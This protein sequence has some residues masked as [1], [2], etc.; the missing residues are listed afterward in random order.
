M[1]IRLAVRTDAPALA[2]LEQRQPRAAGWG[3]HGFRTELEQPAARIWCA[4]DGQIIG[5]VAVRLA[6]GQ[7]EILNVAVDPQYTKQ[8]IGYALLQR[9]LADLQA[10]GTEQVSLE[11]AQDNTA[12]NALYAKAGF[13]MWGQRKDFYGQGKD[14]WIW[15][16]KF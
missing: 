15:G 7:C 4:E 2:V 10:C 11:A 16:K 5:F 1:N 14:A 12:A 9:A 3:E 8:G 6:A 13:A